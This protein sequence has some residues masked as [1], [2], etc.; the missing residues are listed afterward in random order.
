MT[1]ASGGQFRRDAG[2]VGEG[3]A[4]RA[5]GGVRWQVILMVH[6]SPD[7]GGPGVAVAERLKV[8]FQ[9]LRETG[10]ALEV[11]AVALR[12]ADA[13]ARVEQG[14]L[15]GTELADAV[16]ELADNWQVR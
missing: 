6:E 13:D 7:I 15:G 12:Q 11:I 4:G 10:D 5:T 8:D 14:V 1:T 9:L 16:R 2:R 3:A